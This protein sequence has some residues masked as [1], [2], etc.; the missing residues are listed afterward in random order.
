MRSCV[1][2]LFVRVAHRDGLV[3]GLSRVVRFAD[4]LVLGWLGDIKIGILNQ[5]L[6]YSLC[7]ELYFISLLFMLLRIL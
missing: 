3:L 1:C 4:V 7:L 2:I 6:S 5:L